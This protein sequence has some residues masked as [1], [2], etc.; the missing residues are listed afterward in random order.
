[1]PNRWLRCCWQN[2]TCFDPDRGGPM[3]A[4][5][6]CLILSEIVTARRAFRCIKLLSKQLYEG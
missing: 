2:H 3:T 5:L 1:M 4:L 6:F